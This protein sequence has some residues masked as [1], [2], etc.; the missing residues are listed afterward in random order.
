MLRHDI[1]RLHKVA[2]MASRGT[3]RA[4]ASAAMLLRCH[5]LLVG[6]IQLGW[7]R[8]VE[9]AAAAVTPPYYAIRC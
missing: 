2:E 4:L 1:V 5:A 3:G 6:Y 9:A 8:Y 7:I